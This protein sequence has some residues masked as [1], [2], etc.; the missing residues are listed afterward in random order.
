MLARWRRGPLRSR[1]DDE[2]RQPATSLREVGAR[3]PTSH[4]E[5]RPPARSSSPS[6]VVVSSSVSSSS[7]SLFSSSS[8]STPPANGA[9]QKS[10]VRQVARKTIE[11]VSFV[12]TYRRHRRRD[13]RRPSVVVVVAVVVNLAN[14]RCATEIMW[15]KSQRA[16]EID[17]VIEI[18]TRGAAR[19]QATTNLAGSNDRQDQQ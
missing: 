4:R 14:L 12:P 13:R 5:S 3:Q 19:Q 6:S 16:T 18:T 9:I 8:S 2:R 7:S 17:H 1:W 10:Q 11:K 15:S